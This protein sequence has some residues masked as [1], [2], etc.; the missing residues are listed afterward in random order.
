MESLSYECI[1]D[2]RVREQFQASHGFCDPHVRQWLQQPRL[3]GTALIYKD[4]LAH[5]GDD[6]RRLS[7][8]ERDG[9]AGMASL[10]ARRSGRD[11][12]E[13]S[14]QCPACGVLAMEEKKAIESLLDSM[15]EWA[16]EEAYAASSGLCVSHLRLALRA[17]PDEPTFET[18]ID[19]ALARQE[20]LSRQLDE[21]IRKHDPR[22]A[23]EPPGEERGATG[24]VVRYASGTAHGGWEL[25]RPSAPDVWIDVEKAIR[26][27]RT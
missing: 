18:L 16:F 25:T 12:L 5:L 15:Y 3:L 9:F 24:R 13:P 26:R 8:A 22:H 17:A 21:V 27:S 1:N 11:G 20:A 4:V 2:L 6:L 7:Y 14:G 19:T 23:A 10:R